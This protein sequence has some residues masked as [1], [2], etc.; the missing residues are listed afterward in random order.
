MSKI[1]EYASRRRQDDAQFAQAAQLANINLVVAVQVRAL[2][3]QLGLTQRAFAQLIHK[4][5]STVARL[6]T[7]AM[8]ASTKLLSEI[9]LATNQQVTIE[10]SPLVKA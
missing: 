7:G 4:P 5:Q 3:E 6:E 10:F 2:R 8:N 1:D 9:A